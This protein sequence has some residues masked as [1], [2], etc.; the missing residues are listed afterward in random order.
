MRITHVFADGTEKTDIR[1]HVIKVEEAPAFYD[2]YKKIVRRINQNDS[3]RV[4]ESN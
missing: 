2:I 1:G 3:G 4:Q